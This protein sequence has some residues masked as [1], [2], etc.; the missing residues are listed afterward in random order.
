MAVL[1]EYLAVAV[2][3]TWPAVRPDPT[4]NSQ[5]FPSEEVADVTIHMPSTTAYNVLRLYQELTH[6]KLIV[7]GNPSPSDRIT[8]TSDKKLTRP[9]AI[10]SVER[11][12]RDQANLLVIPLD[13]TRSYLVKSDPEWERLA[14]EHC[15][16]VTAPL[17]NGIYRGK[18]IP[19]WVDAAVLPLQRDKEACL[20]VV[21]LGPLAEPFLIQGLTNTAGMVTQLTGPSGSDPELPPSTAA[22]ASDA[23]QARFALMLGLIEPI[24][25]EGITALKNRLLDRPPVCTSAAGA[26][27]QILR[28][29]L[30]NWLP[31][32]KAMLPD[33]KDSLA[34]NPRDSMLTQLISLIERGGQPVGPGPIRRAP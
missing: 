27:V 7:H 29:D 23:R 22:I 2:D 14:R 28:R 9:E 25:R 21:E 11:A 20:T 19:E 5:S 15:S 18:R 1:F 6:R 31:E 30:P 32:F 13:A 10:Q 8:L 3:S 17:S 26:L 24:S 16:V 33:L 4:N 34:S 12:L